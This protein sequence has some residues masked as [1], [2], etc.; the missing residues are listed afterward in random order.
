MLK[1]CLF[2]A[3]IN[4]SSPFLFVPS[5]K[6]N[7]MKKVILT[8]LLFLLV[9]PAFSQNIAYQV[10]AK[11]RD[12][13]KKDKLATA[14]AIRD[15][16]P[17]YPTGWITC[18]LSVEILGTCRGK[19]M[20][21][22]GTSETLNAEQKSILAAADP[23]TDVVVSVK[24]KYSSTQYYV[25]AVP[26]VQAQYPGGEQELNR[27]FK[28]QVINKL[29]ENPGTNIPYYELRVAFTVNEA[30]EIANA[31]LAGSAG[32]AKTEQVLLEAIH[33]MPKWKPAKNTKGETVKQ[34][35]EFVVGKGGGG[36]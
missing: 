22:T 30:G 15:I 36:C 28:E 34:E 3:F 16:I 5:I 10:R 2:S 26:E 32:D 12:V 20:T 23:G 18:N 31:K 17:L 1:D 33:K 25:T 19:A 14:Q 4:N 7:S 35:F 6:T 11:Y 8:P 29:P 27:Y 24:G 13:I 9:I 21:A